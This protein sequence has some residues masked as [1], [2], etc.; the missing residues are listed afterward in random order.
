MKLLTLDRWAAFNLEKWGKEMGMNL[1][2]AAEQ[3]AVARARR[4]AGKWRGGEEGIADLVA[5]RVTARD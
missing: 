5:V 1:S 2:S 3:M 4:R